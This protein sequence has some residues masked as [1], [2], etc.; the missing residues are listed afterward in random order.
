VLIAYLIK[1]RQLH[2][3]EFQCYNWTMS[4]KGLAPIPVLF[5]VFAALVIGGGL[6]YVSSNI[7]KPSGEMNREEIPAN[8]LSICTEQQ[9]SSHFRVVNRSVDGEY[10]RA[11]YFTQTKFTDH[12][13]VINRTKTI[14]MPSI[15]WPEVFYSKTGDFVV[16]CG[17]MV[18]QKEE[19]IAQCAAISKISFSSV[20]VCGG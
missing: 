9:G 2:W 12:S 11:Q 1:A 20:D 18:K 17:G 7:L 3:H 10:Y 14:I 15:D 13:A 5:V 19:A 16:S 4:R 6:W 8:I